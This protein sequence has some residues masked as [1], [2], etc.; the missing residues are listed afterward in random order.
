MSTFFQ[1]LN[2]A[3]KLSAQDWLLFTKSWWLMLYIRIR[4]DFTPFKSW[5]KWL[6]NQPFNEHVELLEQDKVFIYNSRRMIVLASRYHLLNANCLPKSLALKW[7]LSDK[8]IDSELKMG[9][10]LD[11]S[12]FKGHA[13]LVHGD[14]VLNDHV[15]VAEQYPI[16][17]NIGQPPLVN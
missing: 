8:N 13:W 2:T 10:S 11:K 15:D 3:F 9:L 14:L 5:K 1:K 16:E 17:Q 4:M 6:I 7:L 12:N